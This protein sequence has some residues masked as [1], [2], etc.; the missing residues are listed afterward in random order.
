MRILHSKIQLTLVLL[1]GECFVY[2][3]VI[4]TKMVT[5]DDQLNKYCKTI[6]SIIS[7]SLPLEL[8]PFYA[9]PPMLANN[10]DA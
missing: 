4:I 9:V 6:T 10:D 7:S 2:T 3:D 1:G 8:Y 5:N